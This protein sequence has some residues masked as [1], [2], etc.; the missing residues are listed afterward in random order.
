[1]ETDLDPLSL[2]TLKQ[3]ADLLRVSPRVVRVMIQRNELL[4]LRV[5]RQWRIRSSQLARWIEGELSSRVLT[6]DQ[7]NVKADDA[8]SIEQCFGAP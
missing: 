2:L 1:M 4:A 6:P 3:T 5:G 7:Q 8:D